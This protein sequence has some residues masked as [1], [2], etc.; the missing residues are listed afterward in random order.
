MILPGT[1]KTVLVVGLLLLQPPVSAAIKLTIRQTHPNRTKLTNLPMHPPRP[2]NLTGR[3]C[4]D[5][6]RKTPSVEGRIFFSK[7]S[8]FVGVRARRRNPERSEGSGVST[9]PIQRK[10][11]SKNCRIFGLPNLK[12]KIRKFV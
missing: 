2:V 5:I 10:L 1:G 12:S 11:R 7:L 8:R 4:L 6:F 9:S 3:A